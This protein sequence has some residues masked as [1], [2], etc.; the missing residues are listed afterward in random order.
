MQLNA[1]TLSQ[2]NTANC[3]ISNSLYPLIGI[4]SVTSGFPF[5]RV[6]VLSNT[7]VST[8]DNFSKYCPPFIN[9]PSFAPLSIPKD[10]TIGVAIPK[11]Q[12]HDDN[13][14]CGKDSY[15]KRNRL[16]CHEKPIK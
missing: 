11:A 16:V 1:L 14:Y 13:K 6:P 4:T 3:K 15:S 5:V 7:M 8:D 9:T 12:G 10:I 2:D